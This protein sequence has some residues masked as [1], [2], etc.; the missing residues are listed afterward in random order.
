VRAPD[1]LAKRP[2]QVLLVED[3]QDDAELLLLEL[4]RGGYEPVSERV[5]TAETMQEA[6]DRQAWDIVICDHAMPG[7]SSRAALAL[8]KERHLDLP[9]IIVSG[10][11]GEDEAVAVMKAGAHDYLMKDRL[12]RLAPAVERE[13]RETEVRRARK[14]SEERLRRNERGLTDFFENATIGFLWVGPDGIIQRANRAELELLG[15]TREEYLGHHLAEFHADPETLRDLIARLNGGETLHNYDAKLRCK[16]GSIKHVRLSANVLWEDG[17]FVHAR[18][19]TRDITERKLA[20]EDLQRANATMASMLETF[21]DIVFVIGSQ[22]EI[23]F[24]NPAAVRFAEE[25]GLRNA[26]PAEI[27]PLIEQVMAS[28]VHHLPTDF[29]DVHRFRIQ[30]E[31]KFYLPRVVAIR[32]QE[33]ATFGVAVLLQDVTAF[34]L[35]DEVKTNLIATVSH[36]LRTPLTSLRMALLLLLEETIGGLNPR[37]KEMLTIGHDAA[38]QLLRTLNAL[39]DLARFEEGL[40]ET[41]LES[42]APEHIIEAAIGEIRPALL[43]RAL[44]LREEIEDD[45]PSPRIDRVRIIHVLTNLLTNA[46][47][48]SPTGR[49]IIVRCRRTEGKKVRFSVVDQG[50]GIP[51]EFQ[52][53]IF[54]RFFRLPGHRKAGAGLGLAI[55]KEFVQAHKGEI[56]VV[57]QPNAG[58]EFYFD[59]DV[60]EV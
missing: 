50:P 35:L 22:R 55:A 10:H 59:L 9:F 18:C 6:L 15:Y 34:R 49:E 1:V 42:I 44:T 14:Q 60:A 23:R 19:F 30:N 37:Q 33:A 8:V 21:P 29:R 54:D 24:C 41:R 53:R 7:F 26:L 40:P 48:F 31:D 51:L 3:D 36:E 28:G 38:E 47:K 16:N 25:L 43:S 11:I 39:L 58:S 57:S 4:R 13:L 20:E 32:T 56:G 46:I 17:K 2:L 5:E 52:S 27:N 12:A 45:L